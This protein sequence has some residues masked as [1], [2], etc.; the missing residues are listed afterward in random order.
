MSDGN[1]SSCPRHYIIVVHGVG[2]QRHNETTVEVVNRFATVRAKEQP[3]LLVPLKLG[4]WQESSPV[5]R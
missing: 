2:E 3:Q 4:Y 5:L 1:S